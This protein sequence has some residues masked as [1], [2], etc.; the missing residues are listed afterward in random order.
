GWRVGT[1][2]ARTPDE[3]AA[4]EATGA[5]I[6]NCIPRPGAIDVAAN[7]EQLAKIR[8]L[9]LPVSVSAA[10][11]DALIREE[12]LQPAGRADAFDDFFLAYH[13]YGD[14]AT[15]GTIVWYLHELVARYPAL[16]SMQT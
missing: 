3:I 7:D 11:L 16:A 10:D 14:A 1:V 4:V 5:I 9:G 13:R 2:D 12:R 8:D 15:P 6:L